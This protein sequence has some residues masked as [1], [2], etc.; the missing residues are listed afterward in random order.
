[1]NGI[2]YKIL[3]LIKMISKNIC[4]IYENLTMEMNLTKK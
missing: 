3:I 4:F 1:M 2:S